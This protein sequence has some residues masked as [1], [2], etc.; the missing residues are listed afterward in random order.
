MFDNASTVEVI[1]S[2]GSLL[3]LL[4]H[5]WLSAEAYLDWVVALRARVMA[6]AESWREASAGWYLLG[7]FFLFLPLLIH[8]AIG[9]V[10]MTV[11]PSPSEQQGGT[12]SVLQVGLLVAEWM[13]LVAGFGFWMARRALATWASEHDAKYPPGGTPEAGSDA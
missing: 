6:Q 4:F 8:L 10:A 11:P 5:G 9:V 3:A 13:A 7:Q 2:G 1:W 12:S